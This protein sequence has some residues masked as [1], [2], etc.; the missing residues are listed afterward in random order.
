MAPRNTVSSRHSIRT[1]L[2][3]LFIG[4]STMSLFASG[5]LAISTLISATDSAQQISQSTLKTQAADFMVQIIEK[6]AQQNDLILEA[7]RQDAYSLAFFAGDIY[8]NDE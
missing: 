5:Y 7:V 3:L 6:T 4:L 8:A 2:L 1:K